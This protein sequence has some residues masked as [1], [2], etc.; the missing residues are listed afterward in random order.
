MAAPASQRH[1]WYVVSWLIQS[2]LCIMATP[3][4]LIGLWVL[5]K[6]SPDFAEWWTAALCH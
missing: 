5:R 3:V 4:M 6:D 1:S 2:K